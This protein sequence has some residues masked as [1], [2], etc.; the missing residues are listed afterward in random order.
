MVC[1]KG[2]SCCFIVNGAV[3]LWVVCG[4][5]LW[6]AIM[7]T[8]LVLFLAESGWHTCAC[9]PKIAQ[10]ATAEIT[11]PIFFFLNWKRSL[12]F[13]S[14]F[15]NSVK[16]AVFLTSCYC[17]VIRV[18]FP[19]ALAAYDP[20]HLHY[21]EVHLCSGSVVRISTFHTYHCWRL[22]SFVGI[23]SWCEKSCHLLCASGTFSW[24]GKS[25]HLLCAS[26]CACS[27]HV[28]HW[29]QMSLDLCMPV[30]QVMWTCKSCSPCCNHPGWLGVKI[31]YL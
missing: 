10:K 24:C 28:Q 1:D 14:I 19:I 12:W 6:C 20:Q 8:F 26:G 2:L 21:S 7:Y 17:C 4:A 9:S 11:R 3:V 5:V 15:S 13:V 16:G 31:I 29:G 27:G 23:F 30:K 25:C 22:H 18:Y